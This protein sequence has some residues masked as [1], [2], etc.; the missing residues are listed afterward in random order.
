MKLKKERTARF[1]WVEL[2]TSFYNTKMNHC[3]GL[4]DHG[5][6]NL[7]RPWRTI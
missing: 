7:E 3:E 6:L 4:Q 2:E 1:V 5:K